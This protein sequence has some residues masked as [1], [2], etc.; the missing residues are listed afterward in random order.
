MQKIPE[1]VIHFFQHQNFVI[2]ST[3]D[4]RGFPHNSCKGI[5]KI[6]GKRFYLFDLYRG[7]TFKNLQHN[8]HLS[9]TAVDEHKFRGYSLKGRGKIVKL[10]GSKKE[11]IKDWDSI[12]SRRVTHRLLK[13]IQGE[14]GHPTHPEV[15]LPSPKYLIEVKVEEVIDLKPKHIK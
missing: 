1:E 3:L 11:L 12:I 14:K 6:E 13:N 15:N 8:L 5:V 2:V 10:V 9:I 7:K 4:N